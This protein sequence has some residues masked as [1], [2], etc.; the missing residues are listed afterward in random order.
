VF[1][2]AYG[3]GVGLGVMLPF[4]RK[5]ESEADKVGVEF[6]AR[7]KYVPDSALR[8]LDTFV[9]LTGGRATGYLDSH[10]GFQE[11][12]A[13]AAPTVKNQQYDVVAAE[14]VAQKRWKNLAALVDEWQQANPDSAGGWYYRG[15]ALRGQRR[16][17]A[18]AAFEKSAASDPNFASGRLELCVELYRQGRERDSIMCSEYLPRGEAQEEYEARTFQH[19]VIVGGFAPRP[20]LSALGA[21]VI[22]AVAK[23]QQAPPVAPPR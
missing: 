18:L 17:G 19:P 16:A 10:P 22:E 23:V 20:G 2:Q 7:A 12:L 8:L 15:L 11:R 4:S 6:L 21:Q 1:G 9:K 3:L 14:L 13:N 5:Q